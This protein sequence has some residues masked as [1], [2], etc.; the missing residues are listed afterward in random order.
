MLKSIYLPDEKMPPLHAP[1][2]DI[3]TNSGI[4]MAPSVWVETITTGRHRISV[5]MDPE[6]GEGLVT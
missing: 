6:V 3:A 1:N 4:K 2:V 5:A